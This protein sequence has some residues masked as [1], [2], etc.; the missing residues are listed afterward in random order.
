MQSPALLLLILG[1]VLTGSTTAGISNTSKTQIV[2]SG[3]ATTPTN[4]TG[5]GGGGGGEGRGGGNGWCNGTDVILESIRELAEGV[6][7]LASALESSHSTVKCES[8]FVHMHMYL[9]TWYCILRAADATVRTYGSALYMEQ[10]LPLEFTF[11]SNP[12]PVNTW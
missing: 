12:A 9:C 5:G 4:S 2:S 10:T 11:L 1:A 3:D 6:N 8:L 7:R